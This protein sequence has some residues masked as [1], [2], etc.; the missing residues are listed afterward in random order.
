MSQVAEPVLFEVAQKVVWADPSA[1]FVRNSLIRRHGEGP[2]IVW[3]TRLVPPGVD[4]VGH[5]QWL[6]IM[7]EAGVI[8][9]NPFSFSGFWFA[10]AP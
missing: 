9:G 3:E 8:V 5:P 1:E 4:T 6:T 7:D 2:F 10:P